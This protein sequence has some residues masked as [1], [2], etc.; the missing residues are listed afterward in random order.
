MKPLF[1]QTSIK[2]KL[3]YA[4]AAVHAILMSIFIVDLTHR[5]HSFLINES[6]D[7]TRGIAKTLATNSIPW[8]LSNDLAGLEEIM[9]AQAQQTNV[10]FSMVTDANGKV[11]AFYHKNRPDE[12]HNGELMDFGDT[13]PNPLEPFVFYDTAEVIDIAAPILLNQQL[14]GWARVQMSRAHI[15][16]SVEIITA[17]GVLYT[18][19]AIVVGTLFAWLLGKNLTRDIYRLIHATQRV[20]Q[21]ERRLTIS[22]KRKDELQTLSDNFQ[23][24]LA[25]LEQNEQ[26]LFAEKERAEITLKSIG[27]GVITTDEHG[28]VT[29]LN[30][31]AEHLTGWSHQSAMGRPV[32]EVFAIFN[33]ETLQPV[34]NPALKSMVLQKII[35]LANHTILINRTGERISIE[36]SGAPIIDRNGRIIGAV[37]VFHDATDARELKRRLTW[38]A[39][40]D[41]LTRLKNRQAFE[42]RLE[43][44]IEDTQLNPQNEHSLVYIDLD[45]F[46]IVN[47]TVGHQAGDELLKQ[48]ALVLKQQVR[49]H[50]LLARIGGDEFAVLLENCSTDDA[51]NIAEKLRSSLAG[52]QFIW[53]DRS[54]G[55]GASIGIT[56]IHRASHKAGVMSQAD[57]ACYLAKDQGRNRVHIYRDDDQHLAQQLSQLNWVN[58]IKAAIKQEHFVLY[59]QEIVPLQHASDKKRVEI[60]TRLLHED[61]RTITPDQFLPA[62]ERFNLM[63][64][65]DI[66]VTR[67]ALAWLQAHAEQIEL[68][69]INISGQSLDNMQFN[70]ALLQLLEANQGLNHK[71]CFEITETAAI[72]HM[73][74]SISFLNS[75]KNVGCKLALDD[76]GSGFS[77][78]GWL[79][80][81]PVDFV[82]ID[83]NFIL[84][85]LSDSVDAAMVK[86]IHQI[87]VEM[88]IHS[89]AEF[90]E[91][92]AVSDWLKTVGIEYAQGYHFHK[93][94]PLNDFFKNAV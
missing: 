85:V 91:N 92:Q 80:S 40:H 27:D 10:V 31:V 74:A 51:L 39:L 75:I 90:V 23:A 5:Q 65:L 14:L 17:E 56:G 66:Y 79:K 93:P 78:F 87:T 45:Q 83:G 57:V 11:L 35:A 4:I 2:S 24:M 86:A 67:H 49:E 44:L 33:E 47:D 64:E 25:T 55:I 30:P 20:R 22:L 84:D 50:D 42:N 18:L 62:A 32:E 36:D 28:R 38:Q 94:T 60:L 7:A 63:A 12:R 15:A 19:M 41:P 9:G 48:V 89:I 71:V 29:Y 72:T 52:Y 3:I 88:H 58:Q 21:G 70:S 1:V 53:Q 13:P 43:K 82:K 59:A 46:K 77:S 26:A 69:N 81:L 6:F 16:N 68:I 54:F 73:S 8:V 61:G 76:F 34:E 37:L